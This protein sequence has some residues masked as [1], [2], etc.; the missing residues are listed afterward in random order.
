MDGCFCPLFCLG[1]LPVP[2]THSSLCAH[3]KKSWGIG[4]DYQSTAQRDVSKVTRVPVTALEGKVRRWKNVLW[5][6]MV[7][8]LKCFSVK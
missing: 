1:L 6:A 5:L 3:S 7:N 2:V 8:S 4:R